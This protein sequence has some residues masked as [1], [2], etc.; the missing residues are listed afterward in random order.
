M[1]TTITLDDRLLIQLKARAAESG[2]SVSRLIE[3]GARLLMRA[4]AAANDTDPFELITFGSGGRFTQH[5]VDRISTVLE[6]DDVER[7]KGR[8]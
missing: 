1:R 7:Y 3:Q 2:I 6:A 8:E 4:P 5:N